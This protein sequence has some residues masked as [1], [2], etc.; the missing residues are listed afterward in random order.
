MKALSVKQP[1]AALL[2]TGQKTLEVRSMRTNYRGAVVICA[3]KKL[4][5]NY[6]YYNVDKGVCYLLSGDKGFAYDIDF[7]LL[8]H[9]GQAIAFANLVDVRLMRPEDESL[10][11]CEYACGFYVWVFENPRLIEPQYIT[12]QLGIF[13]LDIEPKYLDNA[14][15]NAPTSHQFAHTAGTSPTA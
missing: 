14:T 3:S 2:A 6:D 13:A 15:N 4:H 9:S 7:D 5:E 8:H 1:Y 10:T 12:G 11:G